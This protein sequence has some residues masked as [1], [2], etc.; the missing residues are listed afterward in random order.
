MSPT[1]G[2]Y[3]VPVI[4]E[5]SKRAA[6]W[7]ALPVLAVLLV[8]AALTVRGPGLLRSAGIGLVIGALFRNWRRWARD[9]SARAADTPLHRGEVVDR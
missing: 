2:R 1:A 5:P 6:W 3:G 8:G 9:V 4:A 7:R